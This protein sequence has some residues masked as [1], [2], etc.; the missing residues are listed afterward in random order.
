MKRKVVVVG[1]GPGGSSAAFYLAKAGADVL[2]VDKETWPRD[3]PC[4]DSY[5]GSLYPIFED[6]GIMEEMQANVSCVP[7]CM[8]IIDQK[9][10]TYDF[11]VDPWMIIPRRF[12]DDIIRRAAVKAGADFMENFDVTELI[13]KRGQV[14]GIRGYYNNE[15]M[16]VECDAVVVANGSHSMLTRQLGGFVED[17][18]YINY[19]WRGYFKG[20]EGMKQG[21]VEE[22]YFPDAL[23]N[24]TWSAL[25]FLWVCPMYPDKEEEGYAS[26]GM[27]IPE[28]A[29]D[30]ADMTMEQLFDWW[31]KN[32][33]WGQIHMKNAVQLDKMRCM[34]LPSSTKLQKSYAAG[35]IMIGDAANAAECAFDYGIPSA[36]YGGQ[37]AAKV[38]MDC[39]EKDDF[40]EEA[41]SAYQP[42]AE[43]A[44]ND[45]LV[46]NDFFRNVLLAKKDVMT[47]YVSWAE[48]QPGY[49]NI[50]F[51]GTAMRYIMEILGYSFEISDK[52]I[53][54]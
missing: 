36:M 48:K 47:D 11:D 54:Q 5:L 46:Q 21:R 20:V 19:A 53:S 26:L 41:M 40:S 23:P 43:E 51:Q 50:S 8:R 9:E 14:K 24:P 13:I 38:I 6:M 25:C 17:K 15:P 3:K 35:A 18:D 49:P 29:L 52:Q 34:R 39:I 30:E 27:T 1:A 4:G 42:L 12:G 16:E 28:R 31:C 22:V 10:K 37:I 32:S 33:K 44:L 45:G 7:T 2:L